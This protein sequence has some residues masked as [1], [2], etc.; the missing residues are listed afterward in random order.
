MRWF[1]VVEGDDRVEPKTGVVIRKFVDQKFVGDKWVR[2]KI[3]REY[4]FIAAARSPFKRWFLV[5]F[6]HSL[7]FCK[8]RYWF[9]ASWL[10]GAKGRRNK[11]D[12]AYGIAPGYLELG[13]PSQKNP[14][15]ITIYR[16]A[17]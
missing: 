3:N 2:G 1:H 12:A 5:D 14:R 11:F 13:E 8:P 15:P 6:N 10:P 4:S 16:D 9:R 17:K 7:V